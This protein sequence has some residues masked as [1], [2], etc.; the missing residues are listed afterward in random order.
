[1]LT[2]LNKTWHLTCFK[3]LA[4]ERILNDESFLEI[5]NEAYCK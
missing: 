5:N 2:A 1:M 3:C 4:C